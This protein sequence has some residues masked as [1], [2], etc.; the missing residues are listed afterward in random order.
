MINL[1]TNERII[2]VFLCTAALLGAFIHNYNLHAASDY[3][4]RDVND[5]SL[6]EILHSEIININTA[7]KKDLVRLIGIG[8]TLANRIISY[9]EKTGPFE[10]KEDI[11]NVKG[12]GVV[13]FDGIKN[14]ISVEDREAQ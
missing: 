2:I 6:E 4:L 12:I 7:E 9:R 11:I 5:K 10:S 3:R 14:Y 1:A 8:P 13:K